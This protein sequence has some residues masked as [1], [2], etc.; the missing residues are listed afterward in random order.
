LS[1]SIVGK[2]LNADILTNLF[3]SVPNN[4]VV[5]GYVNIDTLHLTADHSVRN[6]K[7]SFDIQNGKL[8]NG[9]CYGVIADST[10]L[11]L[12]AQLQKDK[13][14]SL[15]SLSASDAGQ[16]LKFFKITNAVEGGTI[17]IVMNDRVMSDK[18][19]SGAFEINDFMAKDSNLARLIAFS[20]MNYLN[21]ADRPAIGFNTCLGSFVWSDNTITIENGKAV[22]PSLGISYSGHYDRLADQF[23]ISGISM[24]TS[25]VLNTNRI[26]GAHAA[27]YYV[28]GSFA[29]PNL[30]IKPLKF[31]SFDVI[32]ET[33]GNMLPMVMVATNDESLTYEDSNTEHEGGKD[34]FISK[35]F[36]RGVKSASKDPKGSVISENEV[37]ENKFGVKINRRKTK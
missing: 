10:T 33:F 32:Q 30:V 18:S 28:T 26:N 36:D 24:L 14:S 8:I 31:F 27:P 1:V 25:S 5:A 34:P 22:G 4:E 12:T 23:N 19:I 16:F 21:G 17:N 9:G 7:G 2:D 29:H 6:V 11:A 3:K 13:K 35:A 37:M 15:V 20:S